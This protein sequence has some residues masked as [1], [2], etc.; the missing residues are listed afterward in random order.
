[1]TSHTTPGPASENV[2]EIVW[3]F[4]TMNEMSVTEFYQL[5]RLRID[6]FVVEQTC[7]YAE[8]DDDDPSIHTQHVQGRLKQSGQLVAGAR[9][10]RAAVDNSGKREV[11]V[12]KIGRV[13]VASEWRGSGVARELM[14]E[15]LDYIEKS[16][17]SPVLQQKLPQPEVHL[18]AQTYVSGFYRDLGFKVV[19]GEYLEDGIPHVDMTLN[20]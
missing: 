20:R 8:L 6:V 17:Q 15:V 5:L 4:K 2:P 18:S 1:M 11:A 12:V 19:S 9:V 7:A 16:F 14:E 13:V 10:I 3:S